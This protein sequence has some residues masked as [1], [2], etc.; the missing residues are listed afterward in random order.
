MQDGS[1]KVTIVGS[2]IVA[3]GIAVAGYFVGAGFME[4]RAQ[5]RFVTVKG[6]AEQAVRADIAIWPIS[7]ATASD[8]LSQ[9]QA[10]IEANSAL[11]LSFLTEGG[12]T[13]EDVYSQQLEVVDQLAQRYGNSRIQGNRFI[14]TKT[15]MVRSG[16]VDVVEK[17][18]NDTGKVVAQ[19][20]VLSETTSPTYTYTQL[21]KIKPAMIAEATKNARTSAEQFAA[22]SGSHVG[23]ILKANQ[24]YFQISPLIS[25]YSRGRET[26]QIDKMVR[27]V[28]NINYLLED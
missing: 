8:D 15:L 17:L 6:L 11:V 2:V 20:V 9:A 7:F 24:G 26:A 4:G 25:S 28:T 21:N 23:A 14:I 19:G 18:S 12:L 10:K 27:V 22:D 16:N 1:V 13:S 3:L 5:H